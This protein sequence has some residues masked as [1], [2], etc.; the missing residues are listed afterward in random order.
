[1]PGNVNNCIYLDCCFNSFVSSERGRY[2]TIG[3]AVLCHLQ[4]L[5]TASKP[6][7]RFSIIQ[8]NIEAQVNK[9]DLLKHSD[10]EYPNN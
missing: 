6:S 2:V 9:I 10:K 8:H 4:T 5:A 1:M 3:V 7:G